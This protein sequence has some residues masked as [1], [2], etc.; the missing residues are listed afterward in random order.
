MNLTH[1]DVDKIRM[2]AN[3]LKSIRSDGVDM[4]DYEVWRLYNDRIDE[5]FKVFMDWFLEVY[6]YYGTTWCETETVYFFEVW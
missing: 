2:A 1:H 6:G 5:V 4:N 3:V